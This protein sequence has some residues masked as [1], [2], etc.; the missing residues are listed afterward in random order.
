MQ[1]RYL[2][3]KNCEFLKTPRVNP[4]LWDVLLDKTKS[5]ECY[6]QSFQNNLVVQLASKAVDAKRHKEV[7]IPLKDV[8]DLSVDALTLP[9]LCMN[10]L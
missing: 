8:Y 4:E 1:K 2:S 5:H 10:F 9:I 7:S 6:F 3:P